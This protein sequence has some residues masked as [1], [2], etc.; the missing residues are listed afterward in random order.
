MNPP[1]THRAPVLSRRSLLLGAS[2]LP[3]LGRPTQAAEPLPVTASFSI[4]GDLVR[5]VGGSRIALT[6][7]VGPDQDA[8]VFEPRP[9]DAKSLLAS[10]LLV[11][12]GL[13]FEP[14]AA[15]LVKS[16]GYLGKTVV[17]SQGVKAR[18]AAKAGHS[19]AHAEADPHAWQNPENVVLYVRNIA[20]GLSKVD[21]TGASNYQSNADAYVKELQALDAWAKTQFATLPQAKRKSI[22]SHDERAGEQERLVLATGPGHLGFFAIAGDQLSHRSGL[23]GEQRLVDQQI[24][25]GNE[26]GVGGNTVAFEEDNC[27]AADD[28]AARYALATAITNDERSRTGHIPQRFEDALAA[29][30]LYDADRNRNTGEDQQHQ[31]I[32]QITQEEVDRT[33]AEQQCK[34]RFAQHV[35]QDSCKRPVIGVRKVI[36]AFDIQSLSGFLFRQARC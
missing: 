28:L 23:A 36:E 19:H 35:S 29:K 8:H 18:H 16:A 13:G 6:M 26:N 12:N 22:T 30:L 33:C 24:V 32:G 3:L 1:N 9:T 4:L 25:G 31:C 20:L 7:L 34:H 17:A 5:V 14:W 10:K 21:P 2:A 27:V 15:R 11:V